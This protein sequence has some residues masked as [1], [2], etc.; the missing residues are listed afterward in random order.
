MKYGYFYVLN[1]LCVWKT[2]GTANN[3]VPLSFSQIIISF[4]NF[5]TLPVSFDTKNKWQGRCRMSKIYAFIV[6]FPLIFIL[7]VKGI[8]FYEYDTKQ[9]Y[10]KDLVDSTAY[11]VKITGILT[12]DEYNNIKTKLG[13]FGQFQDSGIILKKGTYINGALS[14]LTTYTPGTQLSKG[15]AFLIYVK[16]ANVSN[17][18]RVENGGVSTDDSKNIYFKAKAVCRV[19]YIHPE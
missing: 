9:R 1:S 19:E 8:V 5:N 4:Y 12:A 17:Y 16:S 10:I 6:V 7:L 2:E 15:D 18:S 3:A 14:G 13:N 11:T